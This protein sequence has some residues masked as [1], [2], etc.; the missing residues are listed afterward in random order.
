MMPELQKQPRTKIGIFKL[1]SGFVYDTA[2]TAALTF[3]VSLPQ[4][5]TKTLVFHTALENKM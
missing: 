5:T 1:E 3:S 4:P 2:T